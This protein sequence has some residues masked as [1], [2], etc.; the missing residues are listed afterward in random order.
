MATIYVPSPSTYPYRTVVRIVATYPNG[1]RATGSGVIVGPNDVL[2]ASHVV[3]SAENGGAARQ[4]EATPALD[5]SSEPFGSFYGARINYNQV[6]TDGD[7]L[8]SRSESAYD[9]AVVGFRARIS[10]ATGTMGMDPNFSSGQLN[11]TGYPG[12]YGGVYMT[13]DNGRVFAQDGIL[14]TNSLDINPGNSGGP[15]WYSGPSGPYVVGIVSTG[16]AAYNL[17]GSQYST[18]RSWISANDD[19]YVTSG[20]DAN[21]VMTGSSSDDTYRMMLGND[22]C[23]GG[24]GNDLVYGNQGS[25]TLRGG[26]GQDTLFGG[27]D[28]DEIAGGTGSDQVYGNMEND[29]LYGGSGNDTVYGGQGADLVFGGDDNDVLYGNLGDGQVRFLL[30]KRVGDAV[31]VAPAAGAVRAAWARSS[32]SR[33]AFS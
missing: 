11:V 30:D 9:V 27:R 31:T 28:S 25:D 13:N 33:I 12:V 10:T 29:T 14:D 19:L 4:I 7:G 6:D 26:S 21:D 17:G 32:S 16:S 20:T 1:A 22:F 2:T 5:G 8:L 24:A 18:V 3:Y 23:D 15:L